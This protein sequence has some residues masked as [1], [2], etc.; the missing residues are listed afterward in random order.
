MRQLVELHGGTVQV[1]SPGEGQGATFTVRL[2]LLRN[3]EQRQVKEP[4]LLTPPSA[5]PLM[6]ARILIVDDDTDTRNLLVFVLEEAG[7]S[8]ISMSSAIEALQRVTQASPK[9][10]VLI[11]DIGM[12]DMDGYMLMRRIKSH[13]AEQTHSQLPFTAIALTAYAEEVNQQKALAAGFQHYLSKPVEPNDLIT[14]IA[15]LIE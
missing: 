11:S 8:V 2:P 3:P 6:G 10:D 14:A 7:A 5:Y 1:D 15:R 4:V 12:P 9:I 13:F